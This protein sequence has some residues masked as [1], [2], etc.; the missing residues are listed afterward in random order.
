VGESAPFE[1]LSEGAG[2]P[3]TDDAAIMMATRY[4]LA[5]EMAAGRRTLELACAAGHGLGLVARTAQ[6]LVGADINAPMLG[7]A[8]AHYRGRVPVARASAMA[9]PFADASFDF[10]FCLEASYYV[11]EF[12]TC[13]DEIG[14]VAAPGARLLFVNANPERVD[15]IRSPHSSHYQ[16]ADEFRALLTARGW[17][18][19]TSAAFPLDPRDDGARARLTASVRTLARRALEGLHLVPRTLAGRAR[20]KRL[21]GKR[22]RPMPAEID[23]AF[24]PRATVTPVPSG[25]VRGY[26]IIFVTGRRPS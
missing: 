14:R 13:L 4:A 7:R 8:Q 9:L 3:I 5:A 17:V 18:V 1:H 24:A 26:Q 10:V 15:F 22:L 11:P 25:P 6:S 16:S 2:V 20:L 21:L 19:E 12:E 23:D